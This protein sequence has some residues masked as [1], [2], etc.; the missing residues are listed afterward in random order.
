MEMVQSQQPPFEKAAPYYTADNVF[1]KLVNVVEL[2]EPFPDQ[3]EYTLP[4]GAACRTVVPDKTRCMK[5]RL[6]DAM[7]KMA[8]SESPTGIVSSMVWE[9]G[10]HTNLKMWS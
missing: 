4:C 10:T 8:A 9:A 1:K 5:D 6:Q 2:S 7:A 3:V